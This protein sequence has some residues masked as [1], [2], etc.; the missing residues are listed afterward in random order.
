MLKHKGGV[1]AESQRELLL[2]GNAPR[3][4]VVLKWDVLSTKVFSPLSQPLWILHLYRD[5]EDSFYSDWN[6]EK[7][8]GE[9][10]SYVT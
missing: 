2:G 6:K 3:A 9:K 10:S 1:C 8:F 7:F 5:T 4:L